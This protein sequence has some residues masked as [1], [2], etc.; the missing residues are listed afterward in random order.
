MPDF[1]FNPAHEK[2][3]HDMLKDVPGVTPGKMFAYPGY[4][5]N[6]KLAVGLFDTGIVAKVG[7]ERVKQLVGRNGVQAFEPMPGRIWKDW[8]LL[9]ADFERHR[10]IFEEAVQFVLAETSA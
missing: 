10:P 4:K 2:V 1:T 7:A 6:G 9:T 3:L 5:V 8:V